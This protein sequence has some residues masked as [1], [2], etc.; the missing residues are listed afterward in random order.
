MLIKRSLQFLPAQLLTPLAQFVSIVVWTYYCSAETIGVITLLAVFQEL[1]QKVVFGWWT[2]YTLRYHGDSNEHWSESDSFLL[3]LLFV[4]IAV[5]F[6]ALYWWF[7]TGYDMVFYSIVAL[8]MALRSLNQYFVIVCSIKGQALG[9]NICSLSGPVIGLLISIILII[10]FGDHPIYPITGFA[11]GESLSIIYYYFTSNYAIQML[12]KQVV[13]KALYYGAPL[14]IAGVFSWTALNISRFMVEWNLG[15]AAV[16]EFAVGFGLGQRAASLASMLVTPA[17]L[18][19]AMQKM[20]DEGQVAAMKQL[21]DNFALLM[22]VM[23]PALVGIF[24]IK[25]EF[26]PLVIADDFQLAALATF[27]WALLSGGLFAVIYNYCNHYFLVVANTKP[28][29]WVDFSLAIGAAVFS[30]WL[31]QSQ[32]MVGGVI[33]MAIASAIVTAV[34][35]IYLVNYKGLVVPVKPLLVTF[36]AAIA[37]AISVELVRGSVATGWLGVVMLILVGASVY[38]AVM[39]P[40]YRKGIVL[41]YA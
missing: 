30:W 37:M 21:A 26:I 5:S 29:I 11:I 9:F 1:A 2:H 31:V 18:P 34:L 13:K 38:T 4:Q 24:M 41:K 12:S 19:M 32:G 6:V 33:A 8:Y 15:L 10:N 20:R 28:L 35:L 16:G 23:L 17:A 27:P 7:G 3:L 36:S 39:Y 40:F 25:D 22:A 14:L